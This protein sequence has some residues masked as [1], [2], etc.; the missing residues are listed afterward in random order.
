M[1]VAGPGTDPAMLADLADMIECHRPDK[2][3]FVSTASLVPI[4][5][6]ALDSLRVPVTLVEVVRPWD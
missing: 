5:V 1:V 2:V 3:T 6:R 4:L